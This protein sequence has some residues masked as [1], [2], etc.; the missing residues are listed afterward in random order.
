MIA[1][2]WKSAILYNQY[3]ES[4]IAQIV[5]RSVKT[6]D[7]ASNLKCEISINFHEF[8]RPGNFLPDRGK[9]CPTDCRVWQMHT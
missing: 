3:C 6:K 8:A 9:N 1:Q 7:S 4:C 2:G 5:M